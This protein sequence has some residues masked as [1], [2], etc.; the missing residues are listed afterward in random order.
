MGEAAGCQVCFQTQDSLP[1]SLNVWPITS[2]QL[3]MAERWGCDY[4]QYLS[5][6]I[7]ESTSSCLSQLVLISVHAE[8][9]GHLTEDYDKRT[10]LN[11]SSK[12]SINQTFDFAE[13]LFF[14]SQEMIS[15]C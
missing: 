6:L 4:P 12:V 15:D 11:A 8:Q 5:S 14:V 13:S 7:G 9:M 1:R 10:F 3:D 2:L